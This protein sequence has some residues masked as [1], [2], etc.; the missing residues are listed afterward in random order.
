MP[1]H[2]RALVVLLVL[3]G[4]VFVLARAPITPSTPWRRRTSRAATQ[5][6]VRG[7]AGRLSGPHDFWLFM[8]LTGLLLT[9]AIRRE[10]EPLA[11]CLQF[12]LFA[13]PPLEASM[14]GFGIVNQVLVLDYPRLLAITVLLPAAF[15]VARQSRGEPQ[16][17]MVSD[18][19]VI[20]YL[21]VQIGLRYQVDSGTNTARY[22][23]Y[24]QCWTSGIPV[25]RAWRAARCATSAALREVVW[26]VSFAHRW[27]SPWWRSSKRCGTGFS[28]C[29]WRS[30]LGVQWAL[31]QL[32]RSRRFLAGARADGPADRPRRYLMVVALG[33]YPYLRS[34]ISMRAR[35][36][37]GFLLLMAGLVASFSRGPWI[38]ARDALAVFPVLDAEGG[39]RNAEG[40]CHGR[41]RPDSR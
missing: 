37:L 28:T 18:Y 36:W 8:L 22:M 13:V 4:A 3:A 20:G 15:H 14:P 35:W 10:P 27:S 39:R 11:R 34:C 25:L 31:W 29:R 40:R 38:A 2:L 6:L 9:W 19:L 17:W 32:P 16:R 23:V 21:L 7:H 41:R 1:E 33:L 12:L 30:A 24:T 5:S 26:R